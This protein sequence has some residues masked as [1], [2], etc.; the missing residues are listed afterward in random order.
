M[1]Y[2][3]IEKIRQNKKWMEAA[4]P[5]INL[6]PN[7]YDALVEAIVDES[8]TITIPVNSM[9]SQMNVIATQRTLLWARLN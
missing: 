1:E 7:R 4:I 8:N 5:C 3:I 9:T 2:K 6:I